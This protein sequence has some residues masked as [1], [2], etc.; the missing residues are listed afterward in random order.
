MISYKTYNVQT[1]KDIIQVIQRMNIKTLNIERNFDAK[2]E[3]WSLL[4]KQHDRSIQ[5]TVHTLVYLMTLEEK[6]TAT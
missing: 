1:L 2:N 6:Y 3:Q 4:H 5:F